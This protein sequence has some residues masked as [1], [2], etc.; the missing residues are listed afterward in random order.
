M[1]SIGKKLKR[2]SSKESSEQF[3]ELTK[4]AK[5]AGACTQT[6]KGNANG[7]RPATNEELHDRIRD[8][9]RTNSAHSSSVVAVVAAVIA[10]LSMIA[11]WCAVCLSR[12]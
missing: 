6:S 9:I 5:D 10:L 4:L 2:I 3:E 1:N 11:A 7:Y 8:V 12:G